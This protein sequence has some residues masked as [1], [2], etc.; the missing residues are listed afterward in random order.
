ML[1]RF[2]D[3]WATAVEDALT[4]YHDETPLVFAWPLAIFTILV[5]GLPT[6]AYLIVKLFI[7]RKFKC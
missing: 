2:E 7:P 4:F 5:C 3:F 6:V 1:E